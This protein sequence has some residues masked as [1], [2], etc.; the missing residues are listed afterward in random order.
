[1]INPMNYCTIYFPS[2]W[3]IARVKQY[4]QVRG[5]SPMSDIQRDPI[6]WQHCITYPVLLDAA[7]PNLSPQKLLRPPIMAV[8]LIASLA[9]SQSRRR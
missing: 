2:T 3:G 5:L 1:M 7:R 6:T 8:A 9:M 4:R